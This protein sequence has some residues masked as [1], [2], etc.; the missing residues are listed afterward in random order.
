MAKTVRKSIEEL[1]EEVVKTNELLIELALILESISFV[2]GISSDAD[3]TGIDGYISRRR[4]EL[5]AR[6]GE[7]VEV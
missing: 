3:Q 6:F 2:T 7:P 4:G 5:R 1:K